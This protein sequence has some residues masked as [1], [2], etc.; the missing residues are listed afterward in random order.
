MIAVNELVNQAYKALT[1]TGIGESTEG[2]YALIG[3]QELNRLISTLNS[4]GFLSLTQHAVELHPSRKYFFKKLR[5]GE[6]AP[7]YVVDMAPP[8]KIEGVM[9]RIGVR[10]IPLHSIDIQQ[11]NTKNLATLPTSWNYSR[12][13][14]VFE[15][16]F[17]EDGGR[18]VGIL[19]LDG[20]PQDK[21]KVFYN[22][23]LP[24]YHLEDTIYLPSLYDELLF[25]GLKAR[26]AKYHNLSEQKK[27]DCD[28]E[29]LAAQTLIKRGAITQRMLQEE[30]TGGSYKDSFYNAFAPTE[31]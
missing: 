17:G 1:I 12:D 7:S 21:V 10:Y 28:T 31:W 29:F 4:Q 26:L 8:E 27:Q 18:E 14:E 5:E 9:R 6:E 15:G 22:S 30:K 3:E 20:T 11:L 13:I 16:E 19:L 23:K 2:D 24:K 25:T